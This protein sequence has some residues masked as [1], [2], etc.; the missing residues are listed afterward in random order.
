[1][2]ILRWTGAR[3][4]LA[5]WWLVGR[6]GRWVQRGVEWRVE[7]GIQRRVERQLEQRFEQRFGQ[8]RIER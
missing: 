7:R 6:F 1:L 4:S 5:R 3:R 8:R 2:F